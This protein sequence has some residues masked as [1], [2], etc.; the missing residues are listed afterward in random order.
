MTLT[1][2]SDRAE[3]FLATLTRRPA[4]PIESLVA[5]FNNVG[6]EL[7]DSLVQFHIKYAGYVIPLWHDE[8]VLGL[9]H[10]EARFLG[11]D[12]IDYEFDDD[13]LFVACADAHPS[14]DYWLSTDGEFSGMGSGGPCASFNE[15]IEKLALAH[16]EHIQR[17]P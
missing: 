15:H 7:P 11:P 2:L 1:L 9:A 5:K 10:D 16:L 13:Q 14:Y 12:G 8:I 3:A 4:V 6:V 17:K